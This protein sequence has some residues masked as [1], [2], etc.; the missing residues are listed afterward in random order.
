M[1]SQKKEEEEV[2]AAEVVVTLLFLIV[3]VTAANALLCYQWE[4]WSIPT[5]LDL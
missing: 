1:R 2:V 5:N 4:N 3:N